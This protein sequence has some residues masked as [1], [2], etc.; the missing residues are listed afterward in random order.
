MVNRNGLWNKQWYNIEMLMKFILVL[1]FALA[2]NGKSVDNCQ[3][4]PNIYAN[5]KIHL[6]I[7][8]IIFY[9]KYCIIEVQH[10]E[11]LK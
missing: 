9:G 3:M 7:L 4:Y 5:M 8:K 6:N 2:K 1:Q 10:T 11:N